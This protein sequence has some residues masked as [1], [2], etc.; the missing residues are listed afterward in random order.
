MLCLQDLIA[1]KRNSTAQQAGNLPS[2]LPRLAQRAQQAKQE[3]TG[4]ANRNPALV[5]SRHSTSAAHVT[6]PKHGSILDSAV[7]AVTAKPAMPNGQQKKSNIKPAAAALATSVDELLTGQPAAAA[8][9]PKTAKAAVPN[10]RT[11]TAALKQDFLQHLATRPVARAS[12]SGRSSID[13]LLSTAATSSGQTVGLQPPA[14]HQ[15]ATNDSTAVHASTNAVGQQ[16]VAVGHQQALQQTCVML[17]DVMDSEDVPLRMQYSTSSNSGTRSST[18]SWQT[19]STSSAAQYCSAL[20]SSHQGNNHLHCPE[21]NQ[22]PF[23]QHGMTKDA[24]RQNQGKGNSQ[25]RV[26]HQPEHKGQE[27]DNWAAGGVAAEQFL[28]QSNNKLDMLLQST[29]KKSH[30]ALT[31]KEN[32]NR[33]VCQLSMHSCCRSSAVITALTL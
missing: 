22:C 20:P 10:S 9:V 21:A 16:R 15:Y 4:G 33:Q 6:Q 25:G 5:A 23:Q 8:A 29:V 27:E 26:G 13:D 14:V 31:G 32:R 2:R 30:Q 3:P 7:A 19:T 12:T 28:R 17:D 1:N 24:S 11:D 18:S